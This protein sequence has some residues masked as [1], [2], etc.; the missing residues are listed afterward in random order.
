MNFVMQGLRLKSL[1]SELLGNQVGQLTG[2]RA[3]QMP[4]VLPRMA[5]INRDTHHLLKTCLSIYLFDAAVKVGM[6]LS[7]DLCQNL[8]QPF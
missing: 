8:V 2:E 4:T 1:H 7:F 5:V 6:F 3:K